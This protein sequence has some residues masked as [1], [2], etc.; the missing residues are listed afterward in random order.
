MFKVCFVL[1]AF[2]MLQLPLQQEDVVILDDPQYFI[3]DDT[4]D[5]YEGIPCDECPCCRYWNGF[6]PWMQEEEDTP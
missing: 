1:L 2:F 6:Q 3:E 4:W 5:E